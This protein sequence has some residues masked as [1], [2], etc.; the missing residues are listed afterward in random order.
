VDEIADQVKD[1]FLAGEIL[2]KRADRYVGGPGDL[3]R[4]GLVKPLFDEQLDS[5][6]GNLAAA[7]FDQIRVFDLGGDSVS[8]G[9][10]VLETSLPDRYFQ[11][12]G[13]GEEDML[14]VFA[15]RALNR[16]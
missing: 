14:G 3:T 13:R 1:V 12:T 6:I 2:V 5:G 10:V 4:G 15:E 16:R 11:S 8:T 7:A 9:G